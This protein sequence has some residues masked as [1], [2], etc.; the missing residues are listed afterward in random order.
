[1]YFLINQWGGPNRRYASLKFFLYTMGGSLGMLLSAQ[2]ISFLLGT[3]DI[4]RWATEWPAF[5]GT[6]F[7]IPATT[8]RMFTFWAFLIAFAIKVPVWPF[9]TWLPTRTPRRPRR[10]QCCWRACC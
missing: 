3:W 2:V 4:T 7:G 8:V 9:H 10:V 5:T 1:M 6:V